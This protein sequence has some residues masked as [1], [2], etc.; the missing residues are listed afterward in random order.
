MVNLL[1]GGLP[2][3]RRIIMQPAQVQYITSSTGRKKAVILPIREY[4]RLL[5]DLHDLTVIVER[6]DEGLVSLE[7][8]K[9]HL[10]E[11]AP[12]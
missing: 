1:E 10:A 3:K 7:E 5:E 12:V 8:M 6:H 2:L 9:R 11:R 4:Q